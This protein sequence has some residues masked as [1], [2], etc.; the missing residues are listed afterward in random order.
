MIKDIF[1]LEYSK[2][3]IDIAV[4]IWDECSM[5]VCDD[6]GEGV[7]EEVGYNARQCSRIKKKHLKFRPKQLAN[8]IK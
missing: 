2:Q 8:F 3:V 7:R 6:V 4:V 1:E 5:R